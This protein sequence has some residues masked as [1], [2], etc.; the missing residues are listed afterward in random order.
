MTLSTGVLFGVRSNASTSVGVAS[1]QAPPESVAARKARYSASDDQA[2]IE[3]CL[4][5]D[6]LAWDNLTRRYGPLVYSI[7]RRQGMSAA[8]AD[9]VFQN[10]FTIVFRHL[11]SL[12]NQKCLAAWLITI[13]RRECLHYCRRTPD[14]DDLMEELVDSGNRL[15]EQVEHREQQLLIHRALGRLEPTDQALLSALFLEIPTPSYVEIARRLGMAVGS[16]GPARARSLK[17]LAA[18]LFELEPEAFARPAT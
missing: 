8:D 4:Q 12:R 3:A 13:T 7:P 14:H 5:G 16:I 11:G 2:L 15:T 10:V 18:A 6:E 17:K 9:D 1:Q